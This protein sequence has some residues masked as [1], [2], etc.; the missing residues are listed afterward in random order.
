VR[1]LA[2]GFGVV[3]RP[4]SRDPF[5][6][7]R[8]ARA[9][10]AAGLPGSRLAI[11]PGDHRMG[12]QLLKAAPLAVVYGGAETERRWGGRSGL[13]VRGPGRA[14]A[15]L[16]GPADGGTLAHLARSVAYDGGVRCTNTSVI[17]TVGDPAQLADAVAERLARLTPA[18]VIDPGARLPAF[19]PAHAEALRTSLAQLTGAGFTDH[20]TAR[21]GGDPLVPLAD[22]SSVARPVVLST[23]RDRHP[24][25]GTELPFP[26]AVVAP[27][28]GD[29]AALR[30]SLVL[31]LLGAEPELVERALREPTVRAVT[32]GPVPVWPA[33]AGLP[34]D[35]SL[36]G[37]LMEPKAL[38]SGGGGTE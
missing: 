33:R 14:K 16:S 15:A 38:L 34:H 20:S 10:L 35:G 11:L 37:F 17:R 12:D 19:D 6:P 32:T 24:L 8:L 4:G 27:W 30:E 18:P 28:R 1:A 25:I 3:V 9:L 2:L 21:Y 13:L 5:T 31:N 7:M 29:L 26:F 22:G 36:T 23:D